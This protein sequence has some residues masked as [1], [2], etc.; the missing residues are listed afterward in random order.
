MIRPKTRYPENPS[1]MTCRRPRRSHSQAP[2]NT[3]GKAMDPS[4]SCHSAVDRITFEPESTT[5]LRDDAREDAIRKGDEVVKEPSA[6]CSY[7]GSP[8]VSKDEEVWHML[9]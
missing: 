7:E 2:R 1:I 4:S 9:P 5:L 6:T 8:V 3:P